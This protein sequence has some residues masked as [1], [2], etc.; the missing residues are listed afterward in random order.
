MATLKRIKT[1]S[2]RSQVYVQLKSRLMEGVWKVGEKLPSENELCNTFGVSRVTVR[3]AIQQ[4]EIL[5][6]VETKHGGG[7]F[8]KD[9][10]T[11]HA[12][13][14]F[15][16]LIQINENQDIITVLEYRKIIEKGAIALA[17]PKISKKDIAFLE[18]TYT[19]MLS[20]TDDAKKNA[21]A[22][23]LFHYRLV[24]IAQ[25]PI[26]TKVYGII[27]VILSA[28]M[29]DVV[30]LLGCEIGLRYHR[31]LIDALKNGDK[32][33]CEA[34]MGDHIEETIQAIRKTHKKNSGKNL[35]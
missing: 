11:I 21:N 20:C 8:V 30:D 5:G 6:L 32:V 25:N 29:V 15:H 7:N 2:L 35:Q 12:M 1:E 28:T 13:D 9:F 26:V 14:A 34:L 23:Y 4:L 24:Q 22:D 31:K 16:P 27:N 10:S 33:E 18:E 19:T 3:A 17:A